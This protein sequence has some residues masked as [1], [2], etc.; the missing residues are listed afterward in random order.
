MSDIRILNGTNEKISELFFDFNANLLSNYN[1]F[2]NRD[3]YSLNTMPSLE[4]LFKVQDYLKTI[5]AGD[6]NFY[7]KFIYSFLGN[8]FLD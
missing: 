3:F 4:I 5:P 6:K 1:Q 8:N 2:L 7:V